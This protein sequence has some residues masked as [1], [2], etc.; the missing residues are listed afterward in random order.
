MINH[1]R[2]TSVIYLTIVVPV[3]ASCGLPVGLDSPDH[4][5]ICN[6][7][8]AT[9]YDR[10]GPSIGLTEAFLGTK[11][12]DQ[13][14]LKMQSAVLP[15]NDIFTPMEG[16][17]CKKEKGPCVQDAEVLT[18][19]TSVLYGEWPPE[20]AGRDAEIQAIVDTDWKWLGTQYNN[21][22]ET[23]PDTP[24]YYILRLEQNDSV[25]VQAD[26]NRA[27]GKYNMHEGNI[28]IQIIYSTMAACKP[29]SL[30]SSYL[31]DLS[32]TTGYFMKNGRLYFELKYDSGSMEFERK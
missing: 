9:C 26:C 27:G 31:R 10:F 22:T 8:Q 19:L 16:I 4:G 32:E 20:Q 11:A 28:S 30:E 25:Q 6:R 29:G 12:A 5:V 18:D 2:F 3:I 13:L 15:E 14:L 24:D 1:A 17:K 7:E 23:Q 21:D